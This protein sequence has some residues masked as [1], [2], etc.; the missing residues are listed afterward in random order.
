MVQGTEGLAF[1]LETVGA[2]AVGE[3]DVTGTQ[4]GMIT[5]GLVQD[6]LG[7]RHRRS[8]ALHHHQGPALLAEDH[9]VG[10]P[11]HAVHLQRILHRHKPRRHLQTLHQEIQHLLPH[12]LLGGEGDLT[13][14]QRVEDVGPPL[15]LLGME[16]L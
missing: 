12:L 3:E 8:L 2:A 4:N 15:A 16:P 14:A 1:G 5:H 6:G 7:E 13:A 9:H 10:T 11:V